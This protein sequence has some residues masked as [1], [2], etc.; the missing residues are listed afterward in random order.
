MPLLRV[1]ANAQVQ[2]AAL[3]PNSLR[4]KI[5]YIDPTL[6]EAT[7]S[8]R[9][10][11]EVRNPQGALKVGMFAN[12][13]VEGAVQPTPVV[14][15]PEDAIQRVREKDVVFVEQ[16]ANSGTFHVREVVAGEKTGDRRVITSGITAG[17]RIAT[18]GSFTIKAQLLKSEFAE[19]D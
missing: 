3:G 16:P 15:V 7:R 6:N 18:K 19:G 2:A 5:T 17:E 12:V 8:G 1:G 13:T 9:A 11:I 14:S 10:R 4:G